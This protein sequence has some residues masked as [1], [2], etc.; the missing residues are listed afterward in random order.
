MLLDLRRRAELPESD[1][2]WGPI[3]ACGPCPVWIDDR[4]AH[5]ASWASLGT[6]GRYHQVAEDGSGPLCRSS[7]EQSG[8]IYWHE[9]DCSF[10]RRDGV[11]RLTGTESDTFEWIETRWHV[12][13]REGRVPA[14]TVPR[15]M[16]CPVSIDPPFEWPPYASPDTQL[17]RLRQRLIIE[18]G[19]A[20]V[21]CGRTAQ[22]IDHDHTTG[23]VR[24]LL[25]RPCN[26]HVDRCPHVTGCRYQ[27]YLDSP[28]VLA[29][30][31]RYPKSRRRL[32]TLNTRRGESHATS[33]TTD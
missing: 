9:Q 25:C 12:R 6:D 4:F 2:A 18:L 26:N 5:R 16:R 17:G 30:R 7:V 1:E 11:Y 24:G 8:F 28:P 32:S 33:H 22:T 14:E 21:I 20:C 13:L 10:V 29:L 27:A 31:L 19:A 15:R 23:M 3:S